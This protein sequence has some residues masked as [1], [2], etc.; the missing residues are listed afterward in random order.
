MI[1]TDKD[2][3][4]FEVSKL[5]DS[6]LLNGTYQAIV[7]SIKKME[8]NNWLLELRRVGGKDSPHSYHYAT[9]L[10]DETAEAL[11]EALK[12]V[13]EYVTSAQIGNWDYFD[14]KLDKARD[15]Y[16]GDQQRRPTMTHPIPE[17]VGARISGILD[18]ASKA[19]RFVQQREAMREKATSQIL[20]LIDEA[21]LRGGLNE[22]D[23]I[24]HPN[25]ADANDIIY[26]MLD[27][28]AQLK[29]KV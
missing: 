9:M 4:E 15:A 14:D 22:L 2:G 16:Q 23:G 28:K 11:A 7:K 17:D 27:L 13:V 29:G 3:Q 20:Q 25:G 24:F 12:A 8:K 26:R 10:T 19:D 5:E 18:L 6:E 21:E 1:L